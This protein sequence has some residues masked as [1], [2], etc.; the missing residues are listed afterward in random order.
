MEGGC[1]GGVVGVWEVFY[2]EETG[3]L[4]E[5]CGVGIMDKHGIKC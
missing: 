4:G 1:T 3:L 5:D 2:E